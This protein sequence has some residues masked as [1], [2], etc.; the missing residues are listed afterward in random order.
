MGNLESVK[1][2]VVPALAGALALSVFLV[3]Q[4]AG[5]DYE[6]ADVRRFVSDCTGAGITVASCRCL[7]EE[8]EGWL[9]YD[10][11][12]AEASVIF[13]GGASPD[14]QQAALDCGVIG[15]D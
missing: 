8:A 7:A 13:E 14:L 2:W 1:R 3:L 15:R 5:H 6:A 10:E 12:R 11:F 9:A 4:S